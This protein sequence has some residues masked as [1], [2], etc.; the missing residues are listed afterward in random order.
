MSEKQPRQR[1]TALTLWLSFLL[2]VNG[3]ILLAYIVVAFLSLSNNSALNDQALT[4][5]F[6][7]TPLWYFTLSF[8]FEI[9]MICSV[10][11]LFKWVKLGFYAILAVTV[12]ILT[13]DVALGSF[14]YQNLLP[15][16]GIIIL[17]F[18]LRPK[19]KILR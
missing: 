13:I 6:S 8:I 14:S 3:L 11:A 10:V 1:G 15:F 2:L 4:S 19:W 9:V 18:L 5:I 16:L 12:V 17:Y 7:T